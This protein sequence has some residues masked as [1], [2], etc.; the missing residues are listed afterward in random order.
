MSRA[1]RS[2]PPELPPRNPAS[3][4]PPGAWD[5]AAAA[6]GSGRVR[7]IPR[8]G[9]RGRKCP[10]ASR[11]ASAARVGSAAGWRCVQG[12]RGVPRGPVAVPGRFL[13]CA[14]EIGVAADSRSSS[15]LKAGKLSA[16]TRPS[17]SRMRPRGAMMGRLRMR[18]RSARSTILLVLSNL[19]PPISHQQA[20]E[21]C[22]NDILKECN[23]PSGRAFVTGKSDFHPYP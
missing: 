3:P 13:R 20:Q 18:L 11:P 5:K 22:G 19:Q 14:P 6:P 4:P 2:S 12:W 23:L 9:I 8:G 1:W 15:T 7:D 10:P 21:T 16:S 17:R